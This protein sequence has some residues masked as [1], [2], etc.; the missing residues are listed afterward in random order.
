M[1]RNTATICK[2]AAQTNACVSYQAVANYSLRHPTEDIKKGAEKIG[3]IL[4]NATSGAREMIKDATNTVTNLSNNEDVYNPDESKTQGQASMKQKNDSM[5][6]GDSSVDDSWKVEKKTINDETLEIHEKINELADKSL[7]KSH[8]Q[9][10]D[11]KDFADIEIDVAAK[12]LGQKFKRTK[13][14]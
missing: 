1:L 4:E 8:H 2:L 6:K 7:L 9:G 11:Y 14:K 3:H 5:K 12:D 10:D 13:N